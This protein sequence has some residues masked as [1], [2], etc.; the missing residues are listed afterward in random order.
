[1]FFLKGRTMNT[2]ANEGG[3]NLNSKRVL[4]FFLTSAS[5]EGK[6]MNTLAKKGE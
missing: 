1:M 4:W 6:T 3:I 5:L 2:L